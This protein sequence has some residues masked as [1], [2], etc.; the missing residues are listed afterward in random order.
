M[1]K[2][3]RNDLFFAFSKSHISPTDY[4][5]LSILYMPIMGAQAYSLYSILCSLLNRQTL[6]SEKYLHTDLESF[7]NLKLSAIEVARNQLEA[8]GLLNVYLYNDCFAYELKAP[9]SPSSFVNDGVLGQY[10]QASITE[11]RFKKIISL[12]KI[13][14][15]DKTNF[16][17][18]T[19]NFEDIYPKI[20]Q[21]GFE[22]IS[23]LIENGKS[24]SIQIKKSDF[25]FRLF[26]D[27][28]PEPFLDK[29][30]LD[31]DVVAKIINL[32]YVYGLDEIEMKDIY[33][34]ATNQQSELDLL[35]LSRYARDAYK[36]KLQS[37]PDDSQVKTAV[38]EPTQKPSDPVQYFKTVSPQTLLADLS[39]GNVS[40]ADLR[41]IERLIDEVKLDK[42][43]VNVLV[44]YTVKIKDGMMPSF[45]YFEKVGMNWRR[46]QID[47]VETAIDYVKHLNSEYEKTKN[48]TQNKSYSK[49]KKSD[50][51]D[52]TIDW[53]ESYIQSQE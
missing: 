37:T 47:S 36:M 45:D 7:L 41:I 24:S 23:G 2:I 33:L 39:G 13:S 22:P 52:V 44:A 43:V 19:K 12:F 25:D 8:I 38:T 29:N 26:T 20:T 16:I 53:L 31:K 50:R 51:P 17:N 4:Q 48:G 35:K 46:N 49:N 27:S 11:D 5:V 14:K 32:S 9:M 15:I 3:R 28:I 34:K 42:G 21:E 10:L 6:S 40:A 1:D 30:Q 18:L